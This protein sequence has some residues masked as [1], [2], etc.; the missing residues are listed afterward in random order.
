M[1]SAGNPIDNVLVG[2]L[3]DPTMPGY[4][5]MHPV[6]P[7]RLDAAADAILHL[8]VGQR[9]AAIDGSASLTMPEKQAL[10]VRSRAMPLRG[11]HKRHYED[12]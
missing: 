4:L 7:M 10:R 3:A 8:P 9:D 5:A 2:P 1:N 6:S 11:S 12:A